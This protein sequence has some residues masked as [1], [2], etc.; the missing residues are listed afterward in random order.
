MIHPALGGRRVPKKDFRAL[1]SQ[2]KIEMKASPPRY[3]NA[4][5]FLDTVLL[6]AGPL[7][8][9]YFYRGNI[10]GEFANKEYDFQKKI[11]ILARMTAT[12][13]SLKMS[14][15]SED[16]KKKYKKECKKFI[17]VVDSISSF[18]WKDCYNSGVGL[19]TRIDEVLIP[20]L[21]TAADD[22]EKQLAKDALKAAGDSSM[23]H[24]M[25]AVATNSTDYRALEGAG[26]VYD[27]LQM[28]D[29]SAAWFIKAMEIVP[30]SL[31]IVQNIAYA[32]IQN[33][34]WDNS[35]TYF[36]KLLE[37]APEDVGTL[38]NIAICYTNKQMYDSSFAFNMRAVKI[39]PSSV[40]VNIDIGV[41]YLHKS[42]DYSNLIRDAQI[43]NQQDKTN[44]LIKKR[45]LLLDSASIFFEKGLELEPENIMALEQYAVINLILGV[46]DKAEIGFKKL[47]EL[48]PNHKDHWINLGDTYIQ[49]QKFEEAIPP[50]EKV[51]ELDPGD[52]EVWNTLGDL[53]ESAGKMDKAKAARSEAKKLEN[54]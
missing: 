2:A 44:S 41:Y 36:N 4:M 52:S 21:K 12:F 45:D 40:G 49:L 23:L 19:I 16:V 15:E 10:L 54:L 24:F 9:A 20:D 33:Q 3:E 47:S 51:V 11:G 48:E 30:E 18:F 6:I 39:D 7:P 46:F 1:L 32:Y 28:Y 22:T 35:I 29:S 38:K 25:A 27:R 26:I 43:D 17:P 53:Y 5:G 14:C 31:N 13:D 37:I 34:D 8:E 42:Q 50:L